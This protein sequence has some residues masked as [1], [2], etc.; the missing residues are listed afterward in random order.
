MTLIAQYQNKN[1]SIKKATLVASPI[2]NYFV[3]IDDDGGEFGK[4]DVIE[5]RNM[6]KYGWIGIYVMNLLEAEK[7]LEKAVKKELGESGKA[8]VVVLS[9]DRKSVV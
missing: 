1:G 8:D 2:R 7:E 3:Y 6:E 5:F 9:T 4:A